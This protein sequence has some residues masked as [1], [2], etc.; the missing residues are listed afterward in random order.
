VSVIGYDGIAIGALKN[1]NLTTVSQP[2]AELGTLAATRLVERIN[3][4]KEPAK[5]LKVSAELL[6]RGTTSEP[7]KTTGL[8]N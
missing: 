2:L 8:A 7:I 3:N 5:Q 1:V 4:P 6:V